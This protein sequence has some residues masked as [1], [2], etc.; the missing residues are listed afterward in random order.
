MNIDDITRDEEIQLLIQLAEK[1]KTC[2]YRECCSY[3]R[4]DQCHNH[5]HVLCDSFE[6]FY[7]KQKQLKKQYP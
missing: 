5:S 4:F 6:E 7:N 3:L 1:E 2:P